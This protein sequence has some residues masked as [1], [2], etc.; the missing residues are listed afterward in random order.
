MIW[1]L[2]RA[3]PTGR[4]TA[5]GLA[6]HAWVEVPGVPDGASDDH[7]RAMVEWMAKK[8][9]AARAERPGLIITRMRNL[10]AEVRS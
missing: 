1:R 6:E 7:M 4:T 5:N 8:Y 2:Y 10:S 3:Q 9:G